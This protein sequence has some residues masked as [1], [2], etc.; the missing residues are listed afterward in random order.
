MSFEKPI[1]IKEAIE[2]IHKKKYLL[3]AI[4]REFVWS[5]VQIEIL[6]D[7]LMRRYPIG[8]FLYWYVEK[9]NCENYQFYEFIRD[10]HERD[11]T[12]NPKANIEG[13]RDVIAVLDGQ[14]R[15]T[16]LYLGLKGTYSYKIPW[17]RW[18]NDAAFPKRK[19]YL[20]LLKRL[21]DIEK[22][23]Y[24]F[25]FLTDE[26]S[27][28]NNDDTYWFKVGDMLNIEKEYDV[29]NYLIKNKLLAKDEEKSRFAN[30]TL[31]KL[32]SVIH[33][34][35]VID[36]YLERDERLD[37]VL[38]IFIRVNSA[39]TTLDY[40]DLLLSIATAQWKEKDAREEIYSFVDEINKVGEGFN[41][42]KDFVLKTALVLCDFSDIAFKV[43]NFNKKNMLK[44]EKCWPEISEAIK[45]SV[46]LIS[47]Y[48]Y[49]R[50]TLT[51]ANA[52]IPISYY[53]YKNIIHQ[54]ILQ[55]S[56]YKDDRKNINKWL[57][58]SLLKRTFSGQPDNV[59]RPIRD[60][61]NKNKQPFPI[62]KI[63]DRFKGEVKSIAFNDD[64]IENMFFYQYGQ[65]YTF[66][67]LA[68][69]YPTLDFRNRF[70]IDHIY[71]KSIFTAKRLNK[72]G[73]DESD[74]QL[75]LSNYN[76]LAN[77]QLLEGLPNQE[78]SDTDFGDWIIS[79]YKDK[80][81]RR[82]FM[83][84]N[85]IPDIDYDIKNFKEFIIKRKNIMKKEFEKKL[86]I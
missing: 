37:K 17:R 45:L 15:L 60:V 64:D 2:N 39:G 34:D 51:S 57:I 50:D 56:K 48:G 78:K 14:Q 46:N 58:L 73:V 67:T 76:T 42:N 70:H 43:D 69:I 62:D 61:L 32:H 49:N 84:K 35:P 24:D 5:N 13:E 68:L 8:S 85:Y 9:K 22:G 31:F 40:S 18:D 7:S 53:I 25:R 86:K 80:K 75:Y 72:R 63:I 11:N 77:L 74:I 81:E 79:S 33:K 59:L 20:N 41:F 4:Q 1:T 47:D 52:L 82:E 27:K 21:E 54:E 26:E 36:Y 30:E 55:S 29:N 38:N 44:I 6:F 12:H 71:P 3:P 65:S 66:S 10:Y 16:A 28:I 23:E 83:E 19:L